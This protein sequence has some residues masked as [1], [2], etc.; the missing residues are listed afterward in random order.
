MSSAVTGDG[1]LDIVAVSSSDGS[2][3]LLG[4]NGGSAPTFTPI[5]LSQWDGGVPNAASVAL[6]L[7]NNDSAV[8]VV[9]VGSASTVVLYLATPGPSSGSGGGAGNFTRREVPTSLGPARSVVVADVDGLPPLDLVVLAA[10][11]SLAWYQAG[12][13]PDGAQDYVEHV[14]GRG[15]APGAAN[16]VVAVRPCLGGGERGGSHAFTT[17]HAGVFGGG[18]CDSRGWGYASVHRPHVLRGWG[19]RIWPRGLA[20]L[21]RASDG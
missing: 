6:A 8:D 15:V 20:C 10:D 18:A 5:L 21:A 14:I 19:G 13:A 7:L 16:I 2:V 11:G 3:R 12:V 1:S 17:T 9:C 4:N